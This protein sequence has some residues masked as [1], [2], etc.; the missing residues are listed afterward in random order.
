MTTRACLAA[1][2]LAVGCVP[3]DTP[4]DEVDW[5]PPDPIDVT[6]TLF[7]LENGLFA[8]VQ[9]DETDPFFLLG[10]NMGVGIPGTQPGELALSYDLLIHWFGMMQDMGAR[11]VRIY[12]LHHPH[13]YQ[14]VQDYNTEHRDNPIYVIHGVWLH[15]EI[16]E[17]LMG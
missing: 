3:V 8:K 11:A 5:D 1:A 12:T 13:F 10:S 7:T 14:A 9:D 15:E 4:L 2:L 6:G 16:E 17:D